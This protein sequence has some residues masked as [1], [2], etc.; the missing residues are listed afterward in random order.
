MIVYAESGCRSVQYM[1]D[2]I[3]GT[4]FSLDAEVDGV[5]RRRVPTRR[6]ATAGND[7]S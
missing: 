5:P 2:L 7:R 3:R 4:H 6:R 1:R